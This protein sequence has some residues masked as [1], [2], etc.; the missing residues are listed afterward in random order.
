MRAPFRILICS[1]GLVLVVGRPAAGQGVTSVGPFTGGLSENFDTLGFTFGSAHSQM[2]IFGG[3]GTVRKLT[4]GSIKY[5]FDSNLGGDQV[6]NRSNPAMIGQLAIAEWSFATPVSRFGG[7]WENNSRFDDARVDFYDS[8]GIL[9]DT[10]TATVPRTA[11]AWT[12]NGWESEV[13][14]GKIV[15]AGN[16]TGFLNGF[17]WYDDMEV[18]AAPVPEPSAV[19]LAGVAGYALLGVLS[20]RRRSLSADG[21]RPGHFPRAGCKAAASRSRR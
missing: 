6:N 21:S 3:F 5:E 9:F 7:Y 14:I 19:L 18:V 10:E 17:I 11:Q 8:N 20:L 4:E 2:T 1:L 16:D 15:V 12:W 13:P